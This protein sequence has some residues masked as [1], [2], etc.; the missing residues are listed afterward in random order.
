[1]CVC[2][3]VVVFCV[4]FF[5]LAANIFLFKHRVKA[6]ATQAASGSV[7]TFKHRAK[8]MALQA[9]QGQS[10]CCLILAEE[11]NKILHI[12]TESS[13]AS[14]PARHTAQQ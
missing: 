6:V 1:M 10:K 9:H 7:Y 13:K 14:Q 11:Y 12:N 5:G 8:A 2:V 3:C 4:A